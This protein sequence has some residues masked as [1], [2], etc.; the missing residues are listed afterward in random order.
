[1]NTLKTGILMWL[2]TVLLVLVG[3]LI[4]GLSGMIIFFILAIVMNFSAYWW[5]D[6]LALKMARA[7]QVTEI[8][9][10]GLHRLVDRMAAKMNM[11]SPQYTS[12]RVIPPTPSPPD[13]A[14]GMRLSPRPPG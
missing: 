11:P 7:R 8:E 6:K 9:E 4:G 3:Q 12:W 1:M 10:P 5:S 2:L 13:E 14:P